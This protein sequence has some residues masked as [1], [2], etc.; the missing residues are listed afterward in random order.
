MKKEDGK[1]QEEEMDDNEEETIN[2]LMAYAQS[3]RPG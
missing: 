3:R 2:E 1:V